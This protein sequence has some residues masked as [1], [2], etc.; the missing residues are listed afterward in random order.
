MILLEQWSEK[1]HVRARKLNTLKSQSQ[2][3]PSSTAVFRF[4]YCGISIQVL[5]YFDSSTGVFRYKV[6]EY[7]DTK[8]WSILVSIGCKYTN[9]LYSLQVFSVLSSKENLIY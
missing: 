7:F 1:F 3:F 8:Y 5:R 6:L 2:Y 9:Y 4:K